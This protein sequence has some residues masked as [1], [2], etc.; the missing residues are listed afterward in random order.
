MAKDKNKKDKEQTQ[1]EP[2]QA[3]NDGI[4]WEDIADDYSD[5]ILALSPASFKEAVKRLKQMY[6]KAGKKADS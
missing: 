6:P 4:F 2:R 3:G 5:S 1:D